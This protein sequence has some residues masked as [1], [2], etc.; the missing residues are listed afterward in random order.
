M[1]AEVAQRLRCRRARNTVPQRAGI[2]IF[3]ID[4]TIGF[5]T[6]QREAACAGAPR[7]ARSERASAR[8]CCADMRGA[9]MPCFYAIRR[10]CRLHRLQHDA[11]RYIDE[12]NTD[13]AYAA[14]RSR[15]RRASS[16]VYSVAATDARLMM[17]IT[18]AHGGAATQPQSTVR[19]H[20]DFVI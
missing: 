17:I 6:V 19:L 1:Y 16:R 18:R 10:R 20:A 14:V 8:V 2:S 11:M 9:P 7:G 15:Q 12:Q 3:M 5:D 13:H 4:D